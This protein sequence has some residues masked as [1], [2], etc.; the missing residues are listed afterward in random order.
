MRRG[1]AA[2]VHG[3]GPADQQTRR[4]GGPCRRSSPREPPRGRLR[5]FRPLRRPGRR[6]PTRAGESGRERERSHQAA[7]WWEAGYGR[8]TA[9]RLIPSALL[10]AT[11]RF[12]GS[13]DGSRSALQVEHVPK[14]LLDQL[15]LAVV[16]AARE[17]TEALR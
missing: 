5:R 13:W 11:P 2:K 9:E 17:L 14:G 3:G 6:A 7:D 1:G 15:R 4:A 10:A 8:V 16:E 12:R